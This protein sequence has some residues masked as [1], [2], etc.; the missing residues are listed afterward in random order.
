M[1]LI[2]TSAIAAIAFAVLAVLI[3]KNEPGAP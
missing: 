3:E 1:T 2:I